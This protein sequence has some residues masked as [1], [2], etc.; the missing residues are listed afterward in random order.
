[1]STAALN[2]EADSTEVL[3]TQH[4]FEAEFP[5]SASQ[6]K[7]RIVTT[8]KQTVGKKGIERIVTLELHNSQIGDGGKPSQLVTTLGRDDPSKIERASVEVLSA[9]EAYRPGFKRPFVEL[10]APA[11]DRLIVGASKRDEKP[12]TCFV[13][14]SE[15]EDRI[16][17]VLGDFEQF[18]QFRVATI[19]A[20]NF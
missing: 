9:I 10:S 18:Y 3:L 2:I 6:T 12:W 1:M 19:H 20:F 4:L 11:L 14:L 17:C 16:R 8:S 5:T 15:N 13:E 7:L